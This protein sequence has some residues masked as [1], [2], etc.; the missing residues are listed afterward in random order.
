VNFTNC[1]VE[2]GVEPGGTPATPPA[3]TPT[4]TKPAETPAAPTPVNN[5]V[6]DPGT[7]QPNQTAPKLTVS[8]RGP[9]KTRAGGTLRY[10]VVVKNTGS[11]VAE[12]VEVDDTLPE[13]A[14]VV[15]RGSANLRSGRLVWTV[16]RLAAGASRTFT[17]VLRADGDATGRVC[18]IVMATGD[19]GLKASA[20]T[21]ARIVGAP[22]RVIPAVTG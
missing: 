7:L 4:P 16:G 2:P 13:T 1:A 22:A 8:K 15:S 12:N 11:A 9:V 14:S 5:P 20:R 3:A 17:V 6:T 21:C 18:N 10:S 19:G